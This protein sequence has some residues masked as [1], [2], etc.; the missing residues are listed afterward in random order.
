MRLR[1]FTFYIS[2]VKE[3]KGKRRQLTRRRG[4]N[5]YTGKVSPCLKKRRENLDP[6][7]AAYCEENGQTTFCK[8]IS[9]LGRG[10]GQLLHNYN[11]H[12][13]G[14]YYALGAAQP[15]SQAHTQ[16]LLGL[17]LW[18]CCASEAVRLG[19]WGLLGTLL[20]SLVGF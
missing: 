17:V 12:A 14:C 7:S 2:E 8:F 9:G 20:V 18:G 1:P 6:T 16:Q 13:V 19:F 10:E 3:V 5:T 4:W 15:S 11:L